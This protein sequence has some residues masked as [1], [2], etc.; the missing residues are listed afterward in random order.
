M[1]GQYPASAALELPACGRI[2]SEGTQSADIEVRSTDC[3]VAGRSYIEEHGKRV[4]GVVPGATHVALADVDSHWTNGRRSVAGLHPQKPWMRPHLRR[5]E[6]AE[7]EGT[8]D[9]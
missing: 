3:I 7:R 9:E 6:S 5:S 8:A 2:N 1:R 4:S